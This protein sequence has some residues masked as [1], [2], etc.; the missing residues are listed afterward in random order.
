M[1]L[2]FHFACIRQLLLLATPSHQ[3][4]NYVSRPNTASVR[5][6]VAKQQANRRS[7]LLGQSVFARLLLREWHTIFSCCS[8]R[9]ATAALL[10]VLF[11]FVCQ[12]NAIAVAVAIAVVVVA[13]FAVL[14]VAVC[15]VYLLLVCFIISTRLLFL[16]F[17]AIFLPLCCFADLACYYTLVCVCL[18]VCVC[19]SVCQCLPLEFHCISLHRHRCMRA[20]VAPTN[21][22]LLL[23]ASL[24]RLQF[25]AFS[26]YFTCLPALLLLLPVLLVLLLHLLCFV[27]V[28]VVIVFVHVAVTRNARTLVRHCTGIA[29]RCW[30]ACLTAVSPIW[31]LAVSVRLSCGIVCTFLHNGNSRVQRAT[32][33]RQRQQRRRSVIAAFRRT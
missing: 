12:C 9:V 33:K 17:F 6:T 10:F 11:H 29:R 25:F 26:C 15:C 4:Q 13:G 16:Q 24:L 32:A 3:H 31:W 2:V 18:C 5:S 30:A 1:R 19:G 28:A 27:V 21:A 20:T 8:I 7:V 14:V 22:S 23:P